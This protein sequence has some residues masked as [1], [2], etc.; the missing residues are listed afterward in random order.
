MIVF[1]ILFEVIADDFKPLCI[2]TT[3]RRSIDHPIALPI[4]LGDRLPRKIDRLA[5][6]DAINVFGPNLIPPI[7]LLD[8]FLVKSQINL[9]IV[10]STF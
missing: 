6:L 2:Q 1:P 5:V 8:R 9:V 4:G 3:I 7:R 10:H